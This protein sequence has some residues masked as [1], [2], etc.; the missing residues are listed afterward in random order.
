M[1]K[2][3]KKN[4]WIIAVV[5]AVLVALFFIY[6]ALTKEDITDT[7]GVRP[8]DKPCEAGKEK[9]ANGNCITKIIPDPTPAPTPTTKPLEVV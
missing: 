6:D 7:T 9:D 5:I 4:L 2:K 8:L 3:T 1:T